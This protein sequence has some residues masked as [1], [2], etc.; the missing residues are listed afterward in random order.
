MLRWQVAQ[1]SANTGNGHFASTVIGLDYDYPGTIAADGA[2]NYYQ[3]NETTG[4]TAED[5][6]GSFDGTINGS[7]TLGV[8]PLFRTGKAISFDGTD[9]YILWSDV[10]AQSTN[11]IR[12]VELAFNVTSF[13]TSGNECIFS[14]VATFP[15]AFSM[16]LYVGSDSKLKLACYR[17]SGISVLSISGAALSTGT[18]YHVIVNVGYGSGA[19]CAIYLNDAT[20]AT[21]TTNDS[22]QL[23][24]SGTSNMRLGHAAGGSYG[25]FNGVIDDLSIWTSE[26]DAA[27]RTDHF[28]RGG[29]S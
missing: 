28:Q 26:Q 25:Y 22:W 1:V 5:A 7:P 3:L 11:W 19:T 20:Y 2:D 17:N 8:S 4:T 21:G 9:D 15:P 13:P 18:D 24:V 29:I 27:Q 14:H 23:S 12:S 10:T 6:L 16:F